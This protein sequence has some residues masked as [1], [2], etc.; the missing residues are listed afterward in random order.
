M[1]FF[2][3]SPFAGPGHPS[4]GRCTTWHKDI[5]FF[6]GW[7][8]LKLNHKCNVWLCQPQLYATSPI[9]KM[10]STY[11]LKIA[12]IKCA[13]PCNVLIRLVLHEYKP[14]T[15]MLSKSDVSNHL[16]VTCF[17]STWSYSATKSL[18]LSGWRIWLLDPV[19]PPP[20]R[21]PATLRLE[22]I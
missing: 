7:G 3:P 5:R 10:K 1:F 11:V 9:C 6:S 21:K 2:L 12:N 14:I 20:W 13:E 16:N 4:T 17:C 18:Q 15:W 22:E 8:N 19:S